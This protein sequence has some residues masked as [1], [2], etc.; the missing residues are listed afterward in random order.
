MAINSILIAIYVC[1]L[2]KTQIKFNTVHPLVSDPHILKIIHHFAT[3][4]QY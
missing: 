2:E 3:Y 4:F 1:N